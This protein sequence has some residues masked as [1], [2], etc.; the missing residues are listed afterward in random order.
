MKI[1]EKL[2]YL[3]EITKLAHRLKDGNHEDYEIFRI[4]VMEALGLR[5]RTINGKPRKQISLQMDNTIGNS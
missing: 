3:E 2:D 5:N 1:Q 4:V